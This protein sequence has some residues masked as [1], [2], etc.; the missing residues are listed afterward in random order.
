MEERLP[1][2][3]CQSNGY[4]LIHFWCFLL[5]KL[6]TAAFNPIFFLANSLSYYRPGSTT[7]HGDY[8]CLHSNESFL[9][10]LL[11]HMFGK[12]QPFHWLKLTQPCYWVHPISSWP[13][14]FPTIGLV[15]LIFMQTRLWM[16]AFKW[17]LSFFPPSLPQN[18][19]STEP[20]QKAA[21]SSFHLTWSRAVWI[22]T[23]F[24]EAT[25][26]PEWMKRC[27][28]ACSSLYNFIII[29][30]LCLVQADR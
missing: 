21:V 18:S 25:K 28:S 27:K 4:F 12:L 5:V 2:L 29:I 16:F 26:M 24:P 30:R 15:L 1:L 7:I 9:S 10:F 13:I 6:Q 23:D 8:G 19:T 14:V 22:L 20:D 3:F 17:K 11:Q